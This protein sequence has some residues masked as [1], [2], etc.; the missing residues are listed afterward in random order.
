MNSIASFAQLT[1]HLQSVNSRKRM[2]VANAV[3]S[4]TLD[5]VLMAVDKG[6]VEAFL[7]GDVAAIESPELF[8]HNLSPFIHIF[9]IPDTIEATYSEQFSTK[10][11]GFFHLAK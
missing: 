11:K 4:H 8:E 2:A 9:D 6:I 3:D 1:A 5:A 7:I 10:K